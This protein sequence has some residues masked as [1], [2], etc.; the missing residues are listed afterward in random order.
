[1]TLTHDT[2]APS[3]SKWH[4]GLWAAQIALALLYSMSVY[5]K[6]LLSPAEM[7]QMGLV[8]AQTAPLALVRFIGFAEL[9]G[10]IGL[11]LP[12]ATRILPRLTIYAAA[13]LLAIQVLAIPFHAYRGEFAA[14]PFNLIYL[15]L[16]VLII[17]GRSSKAVIAPRG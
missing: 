4:I 3:N 8:W 1:M 6:L 14:L 7:G 17:W 9:A 2:L 13:G 15:G 12:A 10:V 5:M 16:A 11:I